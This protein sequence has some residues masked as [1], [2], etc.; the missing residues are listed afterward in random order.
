MFIFKCGKRSLDQLLHSWL[1]E[2]SL[3]VFLRSARLSATQDHSLAPFIEHLGHAC[4]DMRT[5]QGVKEA[6]ADEAGLEVGSFPQQAPRSATGFVVECCVEIPRA[7]RWVLEA[8]F[9]SGSGR[10]PY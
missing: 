9:A 6:H 3:P 7:R 8:T 5:I 1:V 2:V 4:V 10:F